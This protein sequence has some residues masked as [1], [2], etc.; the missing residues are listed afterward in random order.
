MSRCIKKK[1]KSRQIC[2]GDMRDQITLENRSIRPEE[3]DFIEDFTTVITVFALIETARG[4][5]SFDGANIINLVTHKI[6]IRFIPGITEETWVLFDDRRFDIM[7]VES[8]DER[9]DFLLLRCKERGQKDIPVNT[10]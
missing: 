2:I 1:R 8:L 10:L 7:D 4:L 5:E 3:V 6:W 9:K